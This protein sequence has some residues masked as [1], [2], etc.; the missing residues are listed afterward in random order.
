MTA[1]SP[2]LVGVARVEPRPRWKRGWGHGRRL[3][4]RCGHPFLAGRRGRAAAARRGPTTS[5]STLNT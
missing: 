4:S 3:R 5:T 1:C 2:Q